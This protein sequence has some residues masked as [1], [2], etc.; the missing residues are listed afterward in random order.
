MP[1]TEG[2]LEEAHLFSQS[3]ATDG[4][5]ERMAKF[6][7][8]DGQTRETELDLAEFLATLSS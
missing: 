8:L 2:L 3:V 5:Q 6:M 1:I 7:E 4:A